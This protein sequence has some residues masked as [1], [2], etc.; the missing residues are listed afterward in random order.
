MEVDVLKRSVPKAYKG[1]VRQWTVSLGRG[2]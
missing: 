2:R 1:I